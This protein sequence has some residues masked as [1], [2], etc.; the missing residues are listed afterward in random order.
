V[1]RA[2]HKHLKKDENKILN[3]V[4]DIRWLSLLDEL[5]SALAAELRFDILT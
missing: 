3:A 2:R 5:A 1:S 4:T